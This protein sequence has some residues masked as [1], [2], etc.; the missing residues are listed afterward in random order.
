MLDKVGVAFIFAILFLAYAVA[1][2]ADAAE[3]LIAALAGA[4]LVYIVVA[5]CEWWRRRMVA[6]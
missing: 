5:L 4:S 3:V 1:S 6:R 2:P